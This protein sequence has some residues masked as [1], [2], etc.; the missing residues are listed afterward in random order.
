MAEDLPPI[1]DLR[2]SATALRVQRGVMRLLRESFDMACFAEVTLKSGRRAD[3]LGIGPKGEIWIVEI[4]SSL[5]DFQ[6][7]RKWQEYRDFSDKFFF[8]KPPE[9]DADIFPQSEGLIV[10]DGHDGAI[11]RDSP[12]TPLA[13]AR[14]KA[15]TLKLARLGADRIHA[16]MDPGPK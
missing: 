11:L 2:Q 10:A 16:L 6:V 7:D 14:R 12:N 8:A 3:V 5:I 15:L 1:V 13:P 9:L 4:K